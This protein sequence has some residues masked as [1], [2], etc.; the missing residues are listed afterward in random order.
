MK[1]MKTLTLNGNQYEIVDGAARNDLVQVKEDLSALDGKL[2]IT[3][4]TQGSLSYQDGWTRD[5]ANR[6]RS[7]GFSVFSTD[8]IIVQI[9]SGYKYAIREYN[10]PEFAKQPTINS[11]V[12]S[13]TG[14]TFKTGKA[15]YEVNTNHYYRF[16]VAKTDDSAITPSEGVNANLTI[17][18]PYSE[19]IVPKNNYAIANGSL[20]GNVSIRAAKTFNFSD[21]TPPMIE[22]YLLQDTNSRFYRS[23]DLTSKEY[24]FTFYAPSSNI[25][26]WSCGVDANNNIFFLKDAA[27]YTDSDG[28]RLDDAKRENPVYFLASENY[29]IMHTLDFGSDFK[30]AG[31]LCNLGWCVLPNK[32]IIMCE[33]TRGTLATCNVW[34]VSADATTDPNGWTRTWSHAIVDSTSGSEPE[35]KHCHCVQYDFYTGICYFSTGDGTESS[36]IYYS[37]DNGVTWTL[38]HGPNR[39]KCRQLNFVFT[40]DKVYWASDSYEEADHNFFI[41]NRLD[42]GVIDVD[43]AQVIPI[44]FVNYQACYGCCYIRD[45][46][47]I[48]FVDRNDNGTYTKFILMGY[49]LDTD[50]I[51]TIGEWSMIN[52][53]RGG[54]RCKFIDWNPTSNYLRVGFNTRTGAVTDD[55]NVNALCGNLGGT[56]GPGTDRINNLTIY[57]NKHGTQYDYRATTIYV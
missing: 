28:P 19:A 24:L 36:Y 5:G 50:A 38:A 55:T 14:D 37:T 46:N 7:T 45:I 56:N 35:M 18:T 53:Y 44:G 16:V 9:A 54:F 41:A 13:L 47:T 22:W 32:D 15:Q 39:T 31:W 8:N 49:D 29:K 17:T 25:A 52:G 34:H 23:K 3:E 27:G 10:S 1:E 11:Y 42:S 40:K 30:P 57:I 12:G 51:V 48:V 43:N 20:L 21:G 2:T 6:L 26:N 4:Y 33:Y